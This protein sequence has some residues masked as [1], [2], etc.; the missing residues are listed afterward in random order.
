MEAQPLMAA[1]P[2]DVRKTSPLYAG[3]CSVQDAETACPDGFKSIPGKLLSPQVT[4]LSSLNLSK[5]KVKGVLQCYVDT[6]TGKNWEK[7]Q[8]N[9][10]PG[11]K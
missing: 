11:G 8:E 9:I 6:E 10:L 3:W 4:Q 2:W 1:Q 5:V 7:E